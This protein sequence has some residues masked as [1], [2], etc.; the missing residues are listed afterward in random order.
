MVTAFSLYRLLYD[1]I[2]EPHSMLWFECVWRAN[3][4]FG[5][6]SINFHSLLFWSFIG[7][8]LA[9]SELLAEINMWVHN[10]FKSTNMK[11]VAS[12]LL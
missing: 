12:S 8:T 11:D 1:N 10:Y 2:P 5:A 4:L 6:C 9:I 7:F 3:H